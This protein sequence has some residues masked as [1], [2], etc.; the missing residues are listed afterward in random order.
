MA[1]DQLAMLFENE[2]STFLT[3]R[4]EHMPSAAELGSLLASYERLL[5]D[6]PHVLRRLIAFDGEFVLAST[7]TRYE[8]GGSGLIKWLVRFYFKSEDVAMD[9]LRGKMLSHPLLKRLVSKKIGIGVIVGVVML[10]VAYKLASSKGLSNASSL[11]SLINVHIGEINI[12]LSSDEQITREDIEAI[13]DERTADRRRLPEDVVRIARPARR[14][15]DASIV[16]DA[17]DEL[18]ISP[19]VLVEFPV[20]ASL[21]PATRT[22]DVPEARI[23][24]RALDYDHRAK[25]AAIVPQLSGRRVPLVVELTDPK[26]LKGVE[27][28]VGTVIVEWTQDDDGEWQPSKYRL[29]QVSSTDRQPSLY[30]NEDRGQ[31]KLHRKPKRKEL[32]PGT[33]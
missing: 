23:V 17:N 20:T 5:N 2:H 6:C 10:I 25:W 21:E 11:L 15:P 13:I 19:E 29:I 31:K 30:T 33:T 22:T 28:L 18:A 27:S 14:D 24:L 1:N 8:S 26:I 16:L 32:P 12:G 4:A 9:T 7:L 3:N